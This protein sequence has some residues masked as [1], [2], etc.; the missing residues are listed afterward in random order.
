MFSFITQH[1]ATDVASFEGA[2][3]WHAD[4]RNVHQSCCP[5]I[6]CSFLYHK[7]SPKAF[8]R[9]WQYIHPASQPQTTCNHTSP[10]PPH[11]ACSPP[12]SSETSHSDSCW[13]QSVCITKG[14]L[15]KLSET[16]S[17]KLICML[18]V[19]IGVSNWLQ[20]VTDL[21]GQMLT[22]DGVWHIGKV[23]SSRM[24]PGF[25][26][27]GQMADSVCGWAVFWCQCCESS[28]PW[29]WGYGMGRRMLWTTNTGAFYWWMHRD[30]VT[31]SWGPL[32][33]HSSTTITSCCSM[34]MHGP[35]LKGSLRNSWKL[36]T[37]Q[38]L[39]GQH[40]HRTCHPLSMFGMLWIGVYDSVFQFLPIPSNFPQPLKRSGPTFHRPQSTTWS[41]P[42]EG[43]VLHCLRQMV[44]TPDTDQ[45][46]YYKASRGPLGLPKILFLISLFIWNV[47]TS[48]LVNMLGLIMV[49]IIYLALMHCTSYLVVSKYLRNSI[50][51]T[52]L[53]RIC[54]YSL[55]FVASFSVVGRRKPT[56]W[57][58][59]Y[60]PLL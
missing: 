35:M 23:F 48:L 16:V 49:V 17:G 46:W 42:C 34:I 59:P 22:F 55:H 28:G 26:C 31:R 6:E 30:T 60:T 43:D 47:F 53:D 29:W 38:F 8:Q 3:N 36:K 19:L 21:S 7:P 12:R 33:C 24:N 1:N 39:H 51:A 5:W 57:Y 18:V 13:Q 10:G 20:F 2:C 11:P 4:R 50:M 37:S 9:I 54:K 41:T 15:H 45:M 27:S 14:F 40:T 44:V 52:Y 56:H 25:H 58:V 32:L